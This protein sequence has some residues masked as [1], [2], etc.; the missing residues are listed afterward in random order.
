MNPPKL[1]PIEHQS[2]GAMLVTSS[3]AGPHGFGVT[4]RQFYPTEKS[5]GAVRRARIAK[6]KT[7]LDISR[8]CEIS[9]VQLSTIEIGN[10]AWTLPPDE[11]ATLLAWLAT[12]PDEVPG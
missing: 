10:G 7:L 5:S 1:H 11:E 4:L 3:K 8:A 9:P 6:G 2:T 12:F